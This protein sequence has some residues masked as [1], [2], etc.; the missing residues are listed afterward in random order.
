MLCCLDDCV[1]HQVVQDLA[2]LSLVLRDEEYY[3]DIR[4]GK[5]LGYKI[6]MC[7]RT[8]SDQVSPNHTQSPPR[9]LVQVAR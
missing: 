8:V 2:H 6:D 4:F 3:G 5:A 7:F 9:R 1:V